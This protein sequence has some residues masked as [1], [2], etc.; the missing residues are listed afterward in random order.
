[1]LFPKE[2]A[3]K[4]GF[5]NETQALEWACRKSKFGGCYEKIDDNKYL[6]YWLPSNHPN[7]ADFSWE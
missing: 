7:L 1:M 5:D 4:V 6:A 2:T 3:L